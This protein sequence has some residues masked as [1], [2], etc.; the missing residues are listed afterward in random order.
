MIS[1]PRAPEYLVVAVSN[2][3][4]NS[5]RYSRMNVLSPMSMTPPVIKP[6][7]EFSVFAGVVDIG[8]KFIAGD[9]DAGEQGVWRVCGRVFSWRF[10]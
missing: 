6:C 9:N 1:V 10:E 4:E 7:H 8:D 2:S 3:L 5:Q